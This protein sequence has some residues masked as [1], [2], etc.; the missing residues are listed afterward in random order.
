VVKNY[1]IYRCKTALNISKDDEDL[2]SASI[3]PYIGCSNACKYCYVQADKYRRVSQPE[4]LFAKVRVK[5]NIIEKLIKEILKYKKRNISGTICLG[6]ASDPYQFI[7]RKFRLSRG[8]AE[9][10]L[11][12]TDYNLHIFTK[13]DIILDD[14]SL[15][16]DFKD[17]IAVSI[18]L[19]TVNE[20]LKK[21]F[22]P[23]SPDVSRRL[24]C[25][26]KLVNNDIYSGVAVMPVL[27]FITD[28][29]NNLKDLFSALGKIKVKFIWWGTL[30][31]RDSQK[32]VYY[33]L[34]KKYFPSYIE[35]YNQIYN[36][37]ISPNKEYQSMIDYRVRK[38]AK[39]YKIDTNGP[40][41]KS[42][43]VINAI[44]QQ[45]ELNLY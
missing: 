24:N 19:I 20:K 4:E 44:S 45:L 6:S 3:N 43:R 10:L 33:S 12:N 42:K 21:I 22:E 11:K 17:R 38:L 7:E 30:T 37:H 15:F 36:S 34:L 13:S 23:N 8:I 40:K 35:K 2:F 41:I 14:I 26:L 5:T 9:Y 39:I 28:T 25:I 18:S 16:K 27:P 31:L 32:Q 1:E 29:E